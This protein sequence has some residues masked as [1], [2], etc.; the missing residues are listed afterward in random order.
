MNFTIGRIHIDQ[1]DLAIS[2][3]RK[4]GGYSSSE[5]RSSRAVAEPGNAYQL[6][7]MGNSM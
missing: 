7:F 1:K 5:S 3:F 6:W 2:S 4:R